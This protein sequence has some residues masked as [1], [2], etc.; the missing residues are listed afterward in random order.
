MTTLSTHNHI[1]RTIYARQIIDADRMLMRAHNARVR[2]QE[3]EGDPELVAGFVL[4]ER[5]RQAVLTSTVA[6]LRSTGAL[7]DVHTEDGAVVRA[8]QYANV[9]ATA[10]PTPLWTHPKACFMCGQA[11]P[12][13]SGLCAR[14]RA[15]YW[16]PA[17][18]ETD[19]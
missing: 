11:E 17:E 3:V 15:A 4:A 18:E 19:D 16:N 7:D 9:T 12:L 14:C 2:I 10:H 1:Q 6:L 13:V 8:Y 5:C